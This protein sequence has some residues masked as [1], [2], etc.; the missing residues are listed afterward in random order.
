MS[1]VIRTFIKELAVPLLNAHI[2]HATYY[3]DNIGSRKV[4]EKNGF[5]LVTTVQDIF[6]AS[7]SRGGAMLS[8]G[9][10]RWDRPVGK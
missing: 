6:A 3:L 5:V 2:I 1:T 10:L 8:I 4:F 9:L 7:E